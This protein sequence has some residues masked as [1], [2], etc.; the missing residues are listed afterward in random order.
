MARDPASPSSWRL[1]PLSPWVPAILG[2]VLAV[3]A[4]G[5][6]GSI[7]E[8]LYV[9]LLAA[10]LALCLYAVVTR[11][12]TTG[13][14]LPERAESAGLLGL[15]GLV[16][17]TDWYSL[18]RVQLTEGGPFVVYCVSAGLV[19]V[20]ATI[21]S[22]G[23]AFLLL[24]P[25]I[26]RKVALSLLVIFHFGGMVTSFT[27][28]GV[29]GGGPWIPKMLWAHVYRPYLS[30]LYMTNAYHFYSPD[31]GNPSLMWFAV[32][33]SDGSWTWVKEPSRQNSPVGMHYQRMLALPEHA[34]S[35][36]PR[37]PF[38]QQ[39]LIQVAEQTGRFPQVESWERIVARREDGS[40]LYNPVIP[41][42]LDLDYPNQYREPQDVHKRILA[43]AARHVFHAT[44]PPRDKPDLTVVS[45]KVYRVTQHVVSPAELARGVHPLDP[46]R[47]LPIFMGE[48]DGQGKLLDPR[49]PFLYWYLPIIKVDPDYPRG[50]PNPKPGIPG[51]YVNSPAPTPNIMLDC[52]ELHAAG[53]PSPRLQ[54]EDKP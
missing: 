25:S 50:Y 44:A 33:F 12:R 5:W 43:S 15:V 30:F 47:Y 22:L 31:P 14:D 54:G 32:K 52:L 7:P 13:W 53:R 26:P 42:V 19:L 34:F 21:V 28:V 1:L 6:A 4:Y 20:A 37:L 17:L 10:S 3:P 11:L 24:L 38:T 23:G 36:M 29:P 46:V 51:V 39:E 41:L 16:C 49:D 2:L 40:L 18:P 8:L 27:S 48:F 35:P 45:V 9:G